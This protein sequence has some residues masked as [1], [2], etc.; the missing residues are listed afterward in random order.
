M[1][2]AVLAA[3]ALTHLDEPGVMKALA[4]IRQVAPQVPVLVRTQTDHSLEKLRQ[5]GATEIVP[6]A[7][8]GSLVLASHALALAGVP[9]RRVVQQQR[10]A[11]YGLLRG[12]FRGAEGETSEDALQEERLVTLTAP[13][14]LAGR[15][16][17]EALGDLLHADAIH[18]ILKTAVGSM[19]KRLKPSID[20]GLKPI[21]ATAEQ[22]Q[23]GARNNLAKLFSNRYMQP[24][25]GVNCGF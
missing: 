24:L 25:C 22:F 4:V 12:Y 5:A 15:T 16:L 2:I 1:L 18:I 20:A 23:I 10:E 7:M 8:E 14:R 17:D 21:L 11:R 3:V 13:E 9:M 6:E 19:L